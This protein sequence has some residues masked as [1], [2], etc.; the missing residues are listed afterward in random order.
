MKQRVFEFYKREIINTYGFEHMLTLENL[1][2]AG[3][4]TVQQGKSTYATIRKTLRLTVDDVNESKPTDVS[5]VHSGWV[6]QPSFFIVSVFCDLCLSFKL[7]PE[8]RI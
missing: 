6:L 2:K 4:F 7:I 1:E 3:L 8:N 5:Y